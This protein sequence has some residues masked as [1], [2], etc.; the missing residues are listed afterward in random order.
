MWCVCGGFLLHFLESNY[1]GI[2]VKTNYENPVDN[3]Q[4]ILDRGL[5]VITVPGSDSVVEMLK[6]SPF[7]LTRR[8]AEWTDVPKVILFYINNKLLTSSL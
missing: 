4:D 2:L 5:L 7:P 3:A 8:I 1:L 6:N